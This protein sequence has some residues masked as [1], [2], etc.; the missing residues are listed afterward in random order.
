MR[1]IDFYFDFIS[2]Y[3][4]LAS[5][6]IENIALRHGCAVA[7][8]PFRLGV[9]VTKIMGLKP[10]LETPLKGGYLLSDL[11]RMALALDIPLCEDLIVFNPVPVQRLF[12]ALPHE[13]RGTLAKKLLAARWAHGRKLDTLES[14]VE[15][16]A[17][18]GIPRDIVENALDSPLTKEAVD[19]ATRQ[20]ID[21]GVFGS[22][23]CVIDGELFWGVDRLWLL[24]SF[25]DAGCRL[26]TASN[27]RLQALGFSPS[28]L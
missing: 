24:D 12:H 7:W 8:R 2:P 23:T 14:L 20:A 10:L 1:H 9:T 22:P 28:N 27:D 15:L 3:A 4:Y 19:Q 11:R 16:A 13:A 5:T 25:L 26:Q 6:Q 17:E 21:A 18:F